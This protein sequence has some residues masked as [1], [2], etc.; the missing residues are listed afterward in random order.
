MCLHL[1]LLLHWT[2]V[3]VWICC[4]VFAFRVGHLAA[5]KY[6]FTYSWYWC[7]SLQ[8][9]VVGW[10]IVWISFTG[11]KLCVTAI[12]WTRTRVL[13]GNCCKAS[14]D[15]LGWQRC[16][17][18]QALTLGT[19]LFAS[20]WTAGQVIYGCMRWAEELVNGSWC[21]HWWSWNGV[22][23]SGWWVLKRGYDIGQGCVLW[24]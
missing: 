12:I 7:M 4:W 20:C 5:L 13:S 3:V 22:S 1:Y 9:S 24:M 18:T 6:C 16:S 11:C 15:S 10:W 8:L 2:L 23:R 19:G 17:G 14:L 21:G